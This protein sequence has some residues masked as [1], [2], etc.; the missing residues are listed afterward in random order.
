MQ[1]C[2]LFLFL[3]G[4][5]ICFFEEKHFQLIAVFI[6]IQLLGLLLAFGLPYIGANSLDSLP[7]VVLSGPLSTFCNKS[8]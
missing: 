4:G 8:F 3:N 2:D 7:N 1:F 6:R 5:D